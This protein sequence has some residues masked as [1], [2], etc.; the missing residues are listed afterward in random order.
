MQRRIAELEA[1]NARLARDTPLR[2]VLTGS[3]VFVYEMDPE[4][5]YRW[6]C[7]PPGPLS[8]DQWMGRRDDETAAPEHARRRI[9]LKRQVLLTGTPIRAEVT[10]HD[11]QEVRRYDL[12]LEPLRNEA[13]VVV[14]IAG[15]AFDVTALR[16]AA[17]EAQASERRFRAIV[18]DQ[19]EFISR[20]TPE[21]RIT[22]INRAYAVQLGQPLDQVIGTSLLSLMTAEQQDQFQRQLATL[23]PEHPTISYEMAAVLQDGSDGWEHW[24][25]RALFDEQGRLREYQSVGRD[26]TQQRRAEQALRQSEE[27]LRLA[28]EATGIGIF[29][30]DA[31]SGQRRWS[32]EFKHIL[33]L[34]LDT[35]PDPA[36]YSSLIHPADRD[37]VNEQYW[38]SFHLPGSGRY[39]AEYRI[40]RASDGTVRWVLNT[41]RVHFDNS[42]QAV[43]A[44]GTLVDV[45]DRRRTEEALRA[46]EE[47]RRLA[48]EASAMGVWDLDIASRTVQIDA[49]FRSLFGLG[50]DEPAAPE[51]LWQHIHPEDIPTLEAA[52]ARA[53]HPGSNGHYEVEYRLRRTDGHVRW[54]FAKAKVQFVVVDG[55]RRA[56]RMVGVIMDIT[57]R[58]RAVEALVAS[59]AR[60]RVALDAGRMG[61]WS[62]AVDTGQQ[63]WDATHCR[64]FGVEE[65]APATRALF[66][67]RVHPDD[68][69]LVELNPQKLP[70][71]TGVLEAEY[72]VL[73]PSGEE[74]WLAS[75]AALVEAADANGR[76]VTGVTFDVTE[77]RRTE[78]ALLET[79]QFLEQVADISPAAIF[80]FDRQARQVIYANKGVATILGYA[81]AELKKRNWPSM[82]KLAHE[83]D[84][85]VLRERVLA[86]ERLGDGETVEIECRVR[87]ADGGWRWLVNRVAVFARTP[88]G[89]VRQLI[90][91]ALDIGERKGAEAHQRLLLNELSHRVKNTLATM[92]SIVAMTAR[93][94]S[95]VEGFRDTLNGRIL[96]LST[97][98]SLLTQHSWAPVDL[99]TLADRALAAFE[100]AGERIEKQGDG[101]ALDPKAALAVSMALHELATNAAKYGALSSGNGHVRLSWQAV[102]GD[103]IVEPRLD[104]TWREQD[105]PPVTMPA[106]HGFGTRL[107]QQGLAHELGAAVNLTFE[108]RGV[109]CTMSFALQAPRAALDLHGG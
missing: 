2:A 80:V 33:G 75:R 26:V 27:R 19:T 30:V 60:L 49:R 39:Q 18:D 21:L 84:R 10:H 6:V 95:S 15:A 55:E 23:T 11:G 59:E 104:L 107:L 73:L 72:R 46:S 69:P 77:A 76:V 79:R 67:D 16:R 35:Q 74:R 63:I 45:T 34:P 53:K 57:E 102:T 81:P 91:A 71:P 64:L 9:E 78:R 28:I 108:P 86:V 101:V 20:F 89:E 96:A 4:L 3:P 29:D 100:Q 105:G 58:K 93:G 99:R 47:Q 1:E 66:L 36:R 48:L 50:A 17:E 42:G 56:A 70:E 24:T 98:H 85:A 106:R 12:T 54:H 7:N 44:V 61:T 92:Q 43:R 68:R 41:G 94:A 40:V 83:D 87:H 103:G 62:W 8:P 51:M 97:A 109:V 38:G 13:G 32:D 88:S 37:W 65:G 31:V 5:R 14:G 52:L 25:D 82:A 90:G 22:F